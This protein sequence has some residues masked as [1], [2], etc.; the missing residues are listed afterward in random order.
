GET[1][2]P[3]RPRFVRR[4]LRGGVDHRV[5][6]LP[7]VGTADRAAGG[8]LLLDERFLSA[9]ASRGRLAAGADRPAEHNGPPP[10]PAA[11]LPHPHPTRSDGVARGALASCETS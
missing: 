6:V 9:L 8:R 7:E 10:P 2:V 3:L 4:R 5:L 11:H 1:L